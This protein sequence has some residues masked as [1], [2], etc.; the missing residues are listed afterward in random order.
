MAG[1]GS[2]GIAFRRGLARRYRS[3]ARFHA[4]H[5]SVDRPPRE[6]QLNAEAAAQHR[7]LDL[8]SK[9]TRLAQIAHRVKTLPEAVELA[10]IETRFARARDEGVAAEVIAADLTRDQTRAETDVEQVR[11]RAK[12]DRQ[13]MDSGAVNDSKQLTNLQHELDSL[14]R[15]QAELEEVELEIMERV[16]GAAAAVRHLHAQRD[17]LAAERDAKA[18]TVQA[19][20][21]DLDDERSIVTG[22]RAVIA[23]EIPEDLLALYE[24]IRADQAGVG[25]AHL[26]RGRCGGCRLELPPSEIEQL[27]KAPANEV[28]RCEECRRILVRTAESG[29]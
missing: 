7:L 16:E 10:E 6:H 29:L 20:I 12:H 28:I 19:L 23:A 27:R 4:P 1:A 14:A 15:R 13:L 24:R 5:R 9:D 8:Q 26:Q 21:G 3:H 25:A 11:E 17:S 2:D 18:D 22:E